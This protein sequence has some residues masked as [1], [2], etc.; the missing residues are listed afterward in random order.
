VD[1]RAG[2]LADRAQVTEGRAAVA[3]DGDP[4]A[5]VVRRGDDRHGTRGQVEAELEAP[6]DEPGEALADPRRRLVRDVEQRV[7]LVAFEHPLVN[8][9][10]HDV[11]RRE[12]AV[13]VDVAEELLAGGVGDPR[14]LAAQ[15]LGEE[16][17]S[18]RVQQGG[19]VELDVL[20]VQEPGARAPRHRESVA[21]RARRIG[22]VQVHLPEA[23]GREDRL[24]RPVRGHGA[25]LAL[26]EVRADDRRRAIALRGVHR[27]VRE[28]EQVDRGRLDAPGHVLLAAARL[29]QRAFDGRAG[30]VLDVQHACGRV[31]ALERPVEAAVLAVERNL[32]LVDQERCTR[33]GPSR[34]ISATASGEQSPSPARSMSAASRSGVSPGG[35]RDDAALRVPGVRLLRVLGA[36][37]ERHG[38]PAARR[39]ERGRAAGDAG[40]EDEDVGLRIAHDA[41]SSSETSAA[42]T[43]CVSEPTETA[44]A[45]ASA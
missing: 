20:E 43:E 39:R 6:A 10:R 34:A 11:A 26:E 27:V 16:Q 15:R 18:A 17:A 37:H 1:A 33:S 25:R 45:P 14:A 9:A 22:R 7:G 12:L 31:G 41:C 36:G 8:R 42:R 32:Q 23:A 35:L 28:R 24:V 5:R 19:R 13:R 2:D 40:A 30:L 21:A 4:A 29:D 3:V 38:R 44:S